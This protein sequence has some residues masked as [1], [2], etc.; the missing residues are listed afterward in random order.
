[1]SQ[2]VSDEFD[3]ILNELI[4]R[5]S[6]N[7]LASYNPY[8]FQVAWHN[9]EGL[10]TSGE[11]ARQKCL[12][13]A[14][15]IGKTLCGTAEDAIHA[16]G[17]YPDW[18]KGVRFSHA[19]N[20][21]VAGVTVDKVRDTLQRNLLG[22]PHNDEALGTGWIP[23]DK[24]V[25]KPVRKQGYVN[26]IDSVGVEHV[27]GG[28]S[29]IQFQAYEQ[30]PKKF[31]STGFHI[32]HPDEEPPPDI[33]S[34]MLRG[35][36]ATKGIINLTFTPEDGVTEV[37]DGYMNELKPGQAFVTA[38]WEDAPHIADDPKHKA[39]LLA[40]MKPHERD[41]R[42]KGIPQ[43]GSGMVYP[44]QDDLVLVQP[45]EIP[46]WWPRICGVDFGGFEHPFAGAWLAEDRD[47]DTVFLYKE[48]KN[49]GGLPIHCDAL[50]RQ[51]CNWI[52]TAWPHDL[53]HAD[54]HSGRP[55][56]TIMRDDYALNMLPG[57]FCNPPSP[58]QK[59][60]QGGMGVEVG[61]WNLLTAMETGRFKVF[62]T[63]TDWFR[64]KGLYHRKDGKIIKRM[65]DVMDATRYAYQSLRFADIRP[66]PIN[67]RRQIP[68][69]LRNW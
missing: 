3:T 19:V 54:K 62:A 64:E 51:E 48:Y 34:Q 18:W 57:A 44:V 35:V 42:A 63:C 14:N 38:T 65:D 20:I 8:P 69:G 53:G 16:T 58:G 10:D 25:G 46:V 22:D 36:A 47:T 55:L 30:G 52:P 21:L 2:I 15:Q 31:M 43:M 45:F 6:G 61:L 12:M 4:D 24:V 49:M 67:I 5:E 27:S 26:A 33:Y 7:R 17:L 68:R 13:C 11:P 37:V 40:A 32:E 28:V 56:A 66:R 1:M 50:K 23:K 41:M 59:E 39:Q 9:A 60:G 29:R